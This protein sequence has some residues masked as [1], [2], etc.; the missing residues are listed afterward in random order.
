MPKLLNATL[1]LVAALSVSRTDG[2]DAGLSLCQRTP[3]W[4][5][6]GTSS[7]RSSKRLPASSEVS[8]DTPV[9]LLPGR[10]RLLT[11]PML[12]WSVPLAMM[13]GIVLV[14]CCAALAAA[15]LEVTI[16]AT[17]SCTSSFAMAGS[18]PRSPLAVA[19]LVGHVA[20]IDVAEFAH[21]LAER[22]PPF[23]PVAAVEHADHDLARRLR[24]AARSASAA[25][26]AAIATTAC[27][28]FIA[29][30]P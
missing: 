6:F 24:A 16:A 29:L 3:S 1:A 30:S 8:D 17:L 13:I 25:G 11:S 10:A 23:G 22:I 15:T 18:A 2:I 20:A 14:A 9:T 5:L 21:A 19:Q 12:T 27:L 26:K 28:R 7:R 4:V